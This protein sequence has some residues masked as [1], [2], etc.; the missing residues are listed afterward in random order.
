MS[1]E[2][3]IFIIIAGGAVAASIIAV[4]ILALT[5]I[6]KLGGEARL[7]EFHRRVPELAALPKDTQIKIINSAIALP[8]LLAAIGLLILIWFAV[9]R[10]WVLDTLNSSGRG[11]AFGFAVLAMALILGPTL[12]LQNWIV[13]Q[14]VRR[15]SA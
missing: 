5:G 2:L 10:P 13:R 3:F 8:L 9:S 14:K 1:G 15:H 12:V 6:V 11:G 4:G 7:P